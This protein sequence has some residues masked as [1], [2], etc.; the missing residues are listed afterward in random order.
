MTESIMNYLDNF[1]F[2]TMGASDSDSESRKIPGAVRSFGTAAYTQLG[3][4]P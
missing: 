4:L 3:F 1:T 2:R